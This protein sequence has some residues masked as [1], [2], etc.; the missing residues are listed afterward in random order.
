M[1]S[2]FADRVDAERDRGWPCKKIDRQV[3]RGS[4]MHIVLI[5]DNPINLSILQTLAS[6]I[7]GARCSVFTKSEDALDY[8]IENDADV[9]GVDYSMPHITGTEVI[10]RM[11]ASLRHATTPIAMVTSSK[12]AAV[13][14][15]ALDVGATD[16]LTTPVNGSDFIARINALAARHA[17]DKARAA[18]S[19][20]FDGADIRAILSDW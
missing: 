8:L 12:E 11:R 6:R 4:E 16:F 18:R 17:R 7:E 3:I 5:D 20:D 14:K 9:I 1:L 19:Q 10:K 15:R 13:R 2:F